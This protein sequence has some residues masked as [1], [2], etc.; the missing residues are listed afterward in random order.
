MAAAP[1]SPQTPL[2]HRR[3]PRRWRLPPVL[4]DPDEAFEGAGVPEELG[5]SLGLALFQSVRDVLLWAATGDEGRGSLFA[6]GAAE[7][8]RELLRAVEAPGAPLLPLNV[9]AAL[10]AAPADAEPETVRLA[11]DQ[12]SFWAEGAGAPRTAL[13]FAQAAAAVTPRSAEAALRVG[14]LALA[15]NRP[16]QAGTWLRRAIGV[17]RRERNGQVYARSHLVLGRIAERSGDLSQARATYLQ[18]FRSARRFAAREARG[19]AAA[20][21]ARLEH[22]SGRRDEAERRARQA[23]RILGR[24]HP[25]RP[26]LLRFLAELRLVRGDAAGALGALRQLVPL[27]ADADERML[28]LSMLA[29]AAGEAGERDALEEAW[30]DAW[31]LIEERPDAPH[32]ERALAELAHAASSAGDWRRMERVTRRALERTQRGRASQ[33]DSEHPSATA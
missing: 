31:L 33:A 18:A 6:P 11:C 8:R 21:L 12:L 29:R 20:G 22:A 16:V 10:V 28:V 7:R 2:D 25:D 9:L 24:P 3:S 15:A 19:K 30:T 4:R 32:V 5:G 1:P 17:A 14:E 23:L 13:A 27:C 26:L